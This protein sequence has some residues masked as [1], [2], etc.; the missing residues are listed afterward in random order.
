VSSPYVVVWDLDRTLGLFDALEHE[1]DARE[2]TVFLR[3]GIADA[4]HELSRAGFTQTVLTLATS[5]YAEVALRGT[6]LRDYFVEV[7]GVGQRAKGDAEGIGDLLGVPAKDR[8]HRMFFI[9][10][11]PLFDAPEDSGVV[12]HLEPNALNRH[13]RDVVR[14]IA[15]LRELGSGSLRKGFDQ[16]VGKPKDAKAIQLEHAALGALLLVPRRDQC[17]VI[18]FEGDGDEV[19]GTPVTIVP[20][21]IRGI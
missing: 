11:H 18:C 8:P 10:D 2:V 9:G 7:A 5:R 12:F 6:G 14:L 21:S 15:T 16:L 19:G 1:H 17:P 13:A 4:I 20:S 3:P